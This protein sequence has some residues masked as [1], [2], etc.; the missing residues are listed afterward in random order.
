M[1]MLAQNP[2]T[3]EEALELMSTLNKRD[4]AAERRQLFGTAAK[5]HLVAQAREQEQERRDALAREREA[6]ITA[7][8]GLSVQLLV[9]LSLWLLV[10]DGD[11]DARSS[12][13]T[14]AFTH[15]LTHSLFVS[16]SIHRRPRLSWARSRLMTTT[17][18]ARC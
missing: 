10:T 6:Q 15:S 2:E 8:V 11:H 14:H 4:R 7:E 16:V 13:L 9:L 17:L 5:P 12:S 1:K 3:A 18:G